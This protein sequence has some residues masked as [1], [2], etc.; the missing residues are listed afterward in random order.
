MKITIPKPCSENW[1]LMTPDKMGKFCS[2]CSKSVRDFT[3]CTYDEIYDAVSKE[4]NICGRFLNFQL[5]SEF[6]SGKLTRL[7]S[8]A[9]ISGGLLSY[10]NAQKHPEFANSISD[11]KKDT[12]NVVQVVIG[13]ISSFTNEGEPIYFID[14]RKKRA[15]DF[16]NLDDRDIETAQIITG[17]EAV[18]K[19]GKNAEN[20]VVLITTKKKKKS[21]K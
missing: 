10:A 16:R 5:N 1:D 7:L 20:G 14:G 9:L 21:R 13:G 8:T 18:K 6:V 2:V 17:N 4:E 12:A 19:Y 15:K 3:D 11:C